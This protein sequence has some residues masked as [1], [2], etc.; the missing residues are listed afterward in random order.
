M[1]A[2]SGVFFVTYVMCL[3]GVDGICGGAPGVGVAEWMCMV[4]LCWLV[5][6]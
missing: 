4:L 1:G 3:D 2:E 5:G 6:C